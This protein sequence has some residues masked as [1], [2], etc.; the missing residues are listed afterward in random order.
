MARAV[1]EIGLGVEHLEGAPRADPR[2]GDEAPAL[3]DLVHRVVELREIGDEDDELADG[4]RVRKNRA[5]A[6]IDDERGAGGG[7]RID[8]SG[9]KRLPAIEAQ[10]RVEA[11]AARAHE[12]AVFFLFLGEGLHDLDRAHRPVD[13]GIDMAVAVAHFGRHRDD[14]AIEDRD[15]HEQRRHDRQRDQRQG[16][17]RAGSSR[18]A[19]RRAARP[20][21]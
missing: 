4:Q 2:A 12:A 8:H 19:S 11:G 13:E 17:D 1:L 14:L 15:Q 7:Q 18:T 3:R 10:R 20:P 6:D 16:R 21:R 5:R 9:I